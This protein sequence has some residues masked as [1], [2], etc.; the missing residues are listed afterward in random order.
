MRWFHFSAVLILR[1]PTRYIIRATVDKSTIPI[2][3]MGSINILVTFCWFQLAKRINLDRKQN[4]IADQCPVSSSDVANFCLTQVA[5]VYFYRTY[6]FLKI[7][8]TFVIQHY[9]VKMTSYSNDMTFHWENGRM[10]LLKT[11]KLTLMYLWM[12][13]ICTVRWP[14][15]LVFI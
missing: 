13:Y 8:Q 15:V 10:R 12:S 5:M 6:R 14:G 4:W 3:C 9:G 2:T 11:F 1:P 7:L